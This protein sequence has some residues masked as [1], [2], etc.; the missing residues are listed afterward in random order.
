MT[1]ISEDGERAAAVR[2]INDL[3]FSVRFAFRHDLILS[4]I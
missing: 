2:E 3:G 1:G 4:L